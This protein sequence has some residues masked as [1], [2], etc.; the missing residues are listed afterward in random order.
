[1]GITAA[2]LK[3]RWET[4][5]AEKGFDVDGSGWMGDF[6]DALAAGTVDEIHDNA[7]ATGTDS[8]GDT[9]NLT[10]E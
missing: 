10:I 9:H 3:A 4:K 8:R 1:M 6:L 2:S 7:K 5:L